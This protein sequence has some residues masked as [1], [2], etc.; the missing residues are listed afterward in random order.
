LKAHSESGIRFTRLY[1]IEQHQKLVRELK[2]AIRE[3]DFDNRCEVIEGD[4]NEE[5]PALMR[6]IHRRAPT[7]IFLDTQSIDPQWSTITR[8]APW[9]VEFLINFPLGMSINRNP[10]SAKTEAYFGNRAFLTLLQ[11]RGSGKARAL[12]DL[13][14]QG[15]SD[16]GFIHTTQ[17]DRLVRTENGKRLYYLVFVSKHP[18]GENIMNWVYGEPDSRGQGRLL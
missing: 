12:L 6:R 3:L 13:Y 14:K 2:D 4:A 16:L 5:L 15:L 7:F 8:I 9:R 10:N 11:H 17:D 1:F 18:A